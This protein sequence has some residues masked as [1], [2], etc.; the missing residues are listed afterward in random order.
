MKDRFLSSSIILI[1]LIGSLAI[2]SCKDPKVEGSR[3][4]VLEIYDTVNEGEAYSK[5]KLQ[6]YESKSYNGDKHMETM[7][8]NASGEAEGR[9]QFLYKGSMDQPYRSEYFSPEGDLMSYYQYTYDNK[10]HQQEIKGY[11]G[12]TDELLRIETFEY[13]G[14]LR[15]RRDI[16]NSNN[17]IQ[18]SFHFEFDQYGNEAEMIVT[19]ATGDT[20]AMETYQITLMDAENQWIEKWGFVN[21]VPSTY[22]V[23]K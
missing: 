15:T 22:Q 20:L 18:R 23:K 3:T 2:T 11:D 9:Q 4:E 13:N 21:D 19:A 17:V 6:H 7:F 12:Q 14:D 1:A 16:R 8:Y 5:G 10:G